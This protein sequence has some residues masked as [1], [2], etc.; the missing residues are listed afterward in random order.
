VFFSSKQSLCLFIY[1][2]YLFTF[3]TSKLV[4]TIRPGTVDDRALNVSGLDETKCLENLQLA[5]NSGMSVGCNFWGAREAQLYKGEE[6]AAFGVV[7]NMIYVSCSF[8]FFF[9]FEKKKNFI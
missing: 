2:V 8:F 9:F 5:L 1:F 3:L 7:W 4:N 6:K